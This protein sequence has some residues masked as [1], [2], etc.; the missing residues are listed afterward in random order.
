MT[1]IATNIRRPGSE[2]AD[3]VL[4]ALVGVLLEQE[5]LERDEIESILIKDNN[6]MQ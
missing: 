2:Q 5:T 4:D 3:G 6:T 1:K